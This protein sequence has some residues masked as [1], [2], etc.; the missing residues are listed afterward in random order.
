MGVI[1][2][3][4]SVWVSAFVGIKIMKRIQPDNK[5]YPWYAL[6]VCVVLTVFVTWHVS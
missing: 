2:A 1:I 4:L 5:V 3:V 6:C